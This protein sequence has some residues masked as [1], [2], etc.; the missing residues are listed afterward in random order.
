M[1]PYADFFHAATGNAPYDYQTR[2]AS[3]APDTPCRSQL[4]TIPTGLGK[5]AAVVIAWLWNRA[6]LQKEDWPRRLVYC[7]PMRTLVEQ[8]RG[9]VS[10]WIGNIID[11]ADKLGLAPSIREQLIWLRDH[12]PV[13]LMGGE[14]NDN[15]RREWDIYPER[16]AILIGTQDMLLSRALNR[17]YG[18]TRARWPMHFGLLN[19]DALWV[20]D[21]TQLMGVG[22]RTSAQLEG[23]R[24]RLGLAANSV[25]WWASATLD[26]RLL[27]T[28]DHLTLPPILAL[29]END[30]A[31]TS[32][33]ARTH[34]NKKLAP[35]ADS[36]ST[37]LTLTADSAKIV[38][39]YIDTLA[40]TIL[41]KHQPGTLTIVILNRVNRAR[42]L[43]A[44]LEKTLRLARK[45]AALA[46]SASTNAGNIPELTLI[47]SRFRPME[48][49][50]LTATLNSPPPRQN[51]HCHP[52][53]RSRRGHLSPHPHYRTRSLV[54]ARPTLR[55]LQPQR[56]IQPHRR[57]RHPLDQP[58]IPSRRRQDRRLPRPSL[59]SRTTQHSPRP[60]SPNHRRLACRSRKTPRRR[61]P[62]RDQH[63]PLQRPR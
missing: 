17:G 48:R 20:L 29:G 58:R 38:A 45:S 19:N 1:P 43:Y 24:Q 5:T 39:P 57:R 55:T 26:Q 22:V 15:A 35:L 63:P 31:S 18:M 4:I 52:S 50:K 59:Y 16:P 40:A 2:L 47:H 42:D 49:E 32:V 33:S 8:T 46:T 27:V 28:P 11:H 60:P 21:E 12:S 25:T 36:Q 56:R 9:E 34:S 51:P 6:I 54:L 3:T 23:L 44:T 13:I 53:H 41:E 37:P 10:K 30:H 62:P 61:S 14:E 7:L